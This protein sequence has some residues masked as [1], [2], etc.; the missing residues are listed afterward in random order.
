MNKE[1]KKIDIKALGEKIKGFD[2]N[3]L[4]QEKEKTGEVKN[5]NNSLS[6]F[7]TRVDN[8]KY[9]IGKRAVYVDDSVHEILQLIKRKGKM[10]I[11]KLTSYLL[12]R[13]IDEYQDEISKLQK[14]NK[15]LK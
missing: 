4:G 5:V 11:S 12:E 15:Y 14:R 8:E 9:I 6:E 10:N 13:F 1:N 2:V 7:L 3:R